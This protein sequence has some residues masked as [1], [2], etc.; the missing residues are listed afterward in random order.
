[1]N[2]VSHFQGD[3]THNKYSL[4]PKPNAVPPK[5]KWR[6]EE[7]GEDVGRNYQDSGNEEEDEEEERALVIS[8]Q[9][10][11]EE[12]AE[13]EEKDRVSEDTVYDFSTTKKTDEEAFGDKN[14]E[15]EKQSTGIKIKDFARLDMPSAAAPVE[16]KEAPPVDDED[17]VE[18]EPESDCAS[19]DTWSSSLAEDK[20]FSGTDPVI[21]R[22]RS[23]SNG[24]SVY[25]CDFCEKLFTNK[26]HL[27]SH[28]VVHTGE[29]AFVCKTC[30]KT[31]GRKSTLRAHMTTHTKVSNFMCTV[32]E[33]ACNDNNSLEEHMRMHTGEKPFVCTI[34][35]K[36]YAR[37]SHLNVHYRVH[38]GERPFVCIYCN[39]D[40][41][42]KRF[43]NDHLQTAHN[44]VD[45][46]L[47]CPNCGREFAYK[48]SLKQHLKKQMCE[49]NMNRSHGNL[50]SS[51]IAKQFQCPFCDKSY[52]WKQTL[53]QHV[54]I[55]H[56]NKV[57]T[58]EFWRYEL[59]K[60]RKT[61]LD[62]VAN[63]DLWKKQL[64]KHAEETARQKLE[65][66]TA[67]ATLAA[68]GAGAGTQEKKENVDQ[69]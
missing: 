20:L 12:Q 18:S 68:L 56:R 36:A 16:P 26:Y 19:V 3:A 51:A 41:T 46:P 23:T 59:T 57:H 6:G 60:N 58:D 50:S 32:C 67:A 15:K 45:G 33:K 10:A 66:E 39:K 30:K 40:F 42:E 37:K 38:T 14:K 64:G 34:C 17:D 62:D 9:S 27:Q 43:L 44:G 13:E 48:T 47:K 65:A 55:Y 24:D 69:E 2:L 1:M 22:I 35:Q 5:K 7:G 63:E 11:E 61:V 4:N 29:R 8:E 25:Q 54:S 21:R 31:F 28:L 49:R 52:S 53:K